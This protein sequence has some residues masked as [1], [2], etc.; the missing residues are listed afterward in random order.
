MTKRANISLTMALWL[1]NGVFWL[2][3]VG[4]VIWRL[5]AVFLVAEAPELRIEPASV[6]GWPV[7]ALPSGQARNPFDPAGTPWHTASSTPPP[8]VGAGKLRGIMVLPGVTVA[9]TD[10]GALKPAGSAAPGRFLSVKAREVVLQ[11]PSGPQAFTLPGASRP[12]LRQLNRANERKP[13]SQ[14]VPPV[15]SNQGKS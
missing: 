14:P 1:A 10:Q 3:L 4:F 15:P 9:L 7:L 5:Q 13:S 8:V 12:T 11:T 2:L 6:D